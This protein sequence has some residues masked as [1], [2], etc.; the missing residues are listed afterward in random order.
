M[1]FRQTASCKHL[2]YGSL[3]LTFLIWC[4]GPC[5][6][7][8][9]SNVQGIVQDQTGAPIPKATVQMLNTGTQVTETTTTDGAGNYHFVSVAP[10]AYSV[11]AEKSGFSKATVT[12]TLQTG[13]TLNLPLQ[14]SVASISQKVQVTTRLRS[15]IRRKPATN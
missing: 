11:S 6:A 2:F 10:G 8:F 1:S 15:W 5:S 7:Q 9:S 3:V 13:Q 4:A 14:L 12:I